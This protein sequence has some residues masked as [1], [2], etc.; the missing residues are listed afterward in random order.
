MNFKIEK[1]IVNYDRPNINW[2][3]PGKIHLS[4][5]LVGKSMKVLILF[6]RITIN[7]H[8]TSRTDSYCSEKLNG[9]NANALQ[10]VQVEQQK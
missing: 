1:S 4:T 9:F 3:S 2:K 7:S 8:H 5:V 6:V 10:A